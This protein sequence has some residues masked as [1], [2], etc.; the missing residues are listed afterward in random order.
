MPVPHQAPVV[1]TG[2]YTEGIKLRISYVY[3]TSKSLIC[4]TKRDGE[5]KKIR[6]QT[7]NC[8]NYRIISHKKSNSLYRSI[9]IPEQIEIQL[10]SLSI[11]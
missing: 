6:N 11:K 9:N 2:R 7:K 5:S 3:D 4:Y 8:L 1:K 10:S